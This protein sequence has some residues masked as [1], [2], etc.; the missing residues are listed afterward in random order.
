M[1]DVDELNSLVVKFENNVK[2]I[3]ELSERRSTLETEHVAERAD[4]ERNT[5][6]ASSPRS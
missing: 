3:A 2:I 4:A 5:S 1:L 6:L